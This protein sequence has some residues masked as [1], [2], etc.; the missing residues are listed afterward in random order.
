MPKMALSIHD[1]LSKKPRGASKKKAPATP[2][3]P[4]PDTTTTSTTTTFPSSFS[5]S[6]ASSTTS[7][8]SHTRRHKQQ[9]FDFPKPGCRTFLVSSVL[10]VTVKQPII[11]TLLINLLLENG[12]LES[13]CHQL[14]LS[15]QQEVRK[16][17]CLL[18]QGI[19]NHLQLGACPL[20]RSTRLRKE[21]S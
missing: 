11:Y 17:Y 15:M 8:S 7:Y 19:P 14:P 10:L 18:T 20:S 21:F 1:R 13:I 12:S 3:T 9:H 6:S 4:T 5:P 16:V 2:R